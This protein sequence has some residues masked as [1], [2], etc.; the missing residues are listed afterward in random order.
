VDVTPIKHDHLLAREAGLTLATRYLSS[1][2]IDTVVCLDGSEVIG[3]F[4]A[5][6]LAKQDFRAIN[7]GKN[8]SVIPPEYD[9]NH[10]MIFRENILPRI[11]D[12]DVLVLISTVNSG[13]A[14]RKALDTISYYGGRCQGVA[15][16]FSAV[17]SVEGVPV[18]ALFTPKDI[19]GYVSAPAKDCPLCAKGEKI[20]ALINS[21]GFSKL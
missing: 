7:E 10:H 4:L 1:T 8:I 9:I 15:A 14:A 3:A 2:N 18:F 16:V 17:E 12:K 6:N 19:P 21:Y 5:W 11:Q 20:D 13:T